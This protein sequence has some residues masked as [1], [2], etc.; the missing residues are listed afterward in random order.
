MLL[1][2]PAAGITVKASVVVR[3]EN[4]RGLRPWIVTVATPVAAVADAVSVKVEEL[5]VMLGANTA[6]TPLGK[7]VAVSQTPTTT[8]PPACVIFTVDVPLV[9]C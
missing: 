6:V 3:S 8:I 5:I 2:P 7:P 1:L 4:W 9:P